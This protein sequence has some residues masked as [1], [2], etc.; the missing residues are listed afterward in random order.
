MVTRTACESS[1]SRPHKSVPD[2]KKQQSTA[3]GVPWTPAS[4]APQAPR[5]GGHRALHEP[6]AHHLT[7]RPPKANRIGVRGSRRRRWQHF[8][9]RSRC[10]AHGSRRWRAW[11]WRRRRRKVSAGQLA[12]GCRLS[13]LLWCEWRGRW[14]AS[15]SRDR[16]VAKCRWRARGL[17]HWGR[18]A[19]P[20]AAPREI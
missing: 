7:P 10:E 4:V 5:T 2:S 14:H 18:A 13:S 17:R 8:K 6:C 1:T 9:P 20:R 12:D 3:P 11:R 16:V 19:Q 15:S